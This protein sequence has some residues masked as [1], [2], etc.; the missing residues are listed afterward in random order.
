MVEAESNEARFWRFALGVYTPQAHRA[1]FLRAQDEGGADVPL[2]LFCLWTGVEGVRLSRE[3]MAAAVAFSAAW[4]AARVEPLRA[5][6]RD[7]KDAPG[8][9]PPALSESARQKVAIAEQAVERLQMAHLAELR[10]GEAVTIGAAGDNLALYCQ[11]AGLAL[12]EG[13]RKEIES[14]PCKV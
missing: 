1:A 11:M 13:L 12:D 2:L 3:A 4:R 7:W 10:A 9:L 14:F 5:L 8:T 6:R